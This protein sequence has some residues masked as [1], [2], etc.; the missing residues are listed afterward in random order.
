[1]L[2]LKLSHFSKGALELDAEDAVEQ[3]VELLPF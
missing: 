1:M 3:T 2:G